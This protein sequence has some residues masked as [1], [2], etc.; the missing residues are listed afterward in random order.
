MGKAPVH[1][2]ILVRLYV[3]LAHP[4]LCEVVGEEALDVAH[5]IAHCG[6][7]G[8]VLEEYLGGGVVLCR[9]CVLLCRVL[10][11]V[12]RCWMVL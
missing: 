2:G 10:L 1:L 9:V 12:G 5:Q 3:R 8:E 6:V 11:C 4:V 7:Q